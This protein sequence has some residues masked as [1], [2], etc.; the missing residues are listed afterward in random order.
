VKKRTTL[1]KMS[2]LMNG[3]KETKMIPSE[4]ISNGSDLSTAAA[5]VVN[6]TNNGN[7]ENVNGHDTKNEEEDNSNDDDDN[8]SSDSG[9]VNDDE[10]AL[11]HQLE[12][13]E[14]MEEEQEQPNDIQMAPTLLRAGLEQG[15]VTEDKDEEEDKDN[16]NAAH[17]PHVHQRVSTCSK[18]ILVLCA[19][20]PRVTC[21][22]K[23]IF[24]TYIYIYIYIY[25]LQTSQLDFLLSKASEYSN[26][27]ARDLDELQATMASQAERASKKKRKRDGKAKSKAA[28]ESALVKD[29]AAR[30]EKH[31]FVQPPNLAEGCILKDYQLEGVRW[32]VSL[33]ENGVS[34]I[35]ADEMYV[36]NCARE[37]DGVEVY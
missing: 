18:C 33:Y 2:S 24:S 26:F 14:A 27:I 29:A 35:L 8:C 6:G 12:R 36:L 28:L 10:E 4:S 11:F 9:I 32:L 25:I 1:A 34:G 7:D 19:W 15:D 37:C 13:D 30:Q 17:E 21:T 23:H 16:T 31:I 3:N 22:N 5:V 20:Y